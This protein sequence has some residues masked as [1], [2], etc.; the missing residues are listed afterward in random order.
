[1]SILPDPV[2]SV[3]PFPPGRILLVRVSVAR[4]AGRHDYYVHIEQRPTDDDAAVLLKVLG[5]FRHL[6][7]PT[8]R[9][10]AIDLFPNQ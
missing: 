2:P 7:G 4:S 6:H 8:E 9:V 3:L 10:V 1:M 5:E